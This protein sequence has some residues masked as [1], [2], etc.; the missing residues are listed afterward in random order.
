MVTLPSGARY[1]PDFRLP[2]I[3][4]W[5]EAKGTGVPRVEKA[6]EF[7]RS[8]ACD[9]PRIR[10]ILHCSCHY[11]GGWLV[12]IGN[13]PTPFNPWA[14]EDY[15][16]WPWW[17]KVRLERRH[18]GHISW[19]STRNLRT[20]LARCPDCRH[21][22]WFDLPKCRACRGPLVGAQGYHSGTDAFEFIRISGAAV[23][24]GDG[25]DEGPEDN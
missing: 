2:D 18:S 14:S 13:P 20:W 3:G 4:T 7:G 21:V 10:G 24:A 17:S 22:T 19:T 8:L 23:P 9:C 15:E 11:P 16:H 1:L 25:V 5:I 6:V 12:L